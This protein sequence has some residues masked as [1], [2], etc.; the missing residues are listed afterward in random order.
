M[1]RKSPKKTGRRA[2]IKLKGM[3]PKPKKKPKGL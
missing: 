2:W 1:N 3:L